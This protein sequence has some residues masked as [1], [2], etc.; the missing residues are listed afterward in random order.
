MGD[1]MYKNSSKC[2]FWVTLLHAILSDVTPCNSHSMQYIYIFFWKSNILKH[3]TTPAGNWKAG[4]TGTKTPL[5]YIEMALKGDI[6]QL[7]LSNRVIFRLFNH[8]NYKK[9][10]HAN[11][12]ELHMKIKHA[13]TNSDSFESSC[14]AWPF[15]EVNLERY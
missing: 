4:K 1:Q 14:W 9:L 12:L 8:G 6:N 2:V 3:L 15:S 11:D 13:I 7:V 10:L 5:D